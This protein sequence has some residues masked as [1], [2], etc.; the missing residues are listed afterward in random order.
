M[1]LSIKSGDGMLNIRVGAI[2][3]DKN[4]YCFHYD[5]QRRFYA[6]IGGRVKYYESSDAAIKREIKEEL[7][8]ECNNIKFVSTIQ[9]FFEYAGTSYHEISFI[10]EFTLETSLEDLD[11]PSDPKVDYVSVKLPD[12]DSIN[13]LPEKVKDIILETVDVQPLFIHHDKG[14]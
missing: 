2:I 13:L 14:K 3:K 1:D 6:L 7:G 5:K 8:I 9:N 10:Y 11:I 4:G 12:I